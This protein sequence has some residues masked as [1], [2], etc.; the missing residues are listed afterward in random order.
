MKVFILAM[1]CLLASVNASSKKQLTEKEYVLVTGSANDNDKMEV[2]DKKGKT[3]VCPSK[4]FPEKV[5]S[6]TGGVLEEHI[7]ICGGGFPATKGQKI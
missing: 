3:T 6:A 1:F 4:T 7:L 2:I 5:S